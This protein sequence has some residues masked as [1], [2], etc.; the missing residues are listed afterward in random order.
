M[1]V[2][3]KLSRREK[4]LLEELASLGG[5]RLEDEKSF[6]ARVKDAFKAD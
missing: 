3:Q 4:E 1:L 6:F 2:P 5:N